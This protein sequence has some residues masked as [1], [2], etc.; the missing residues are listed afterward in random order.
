MDNSFTHDSSYFQP[1]TTLGGVDIAEA[2]AKY[3]DLFAD[4]I[5]DGTI[6][7]ER[8]AH[9]D[10]A[11]A[12]LGLESPRVKQIEEALVASHEVRH[13]ITVV[14]EAVEAEELSFPRRSSELAPIATSEEPGVRALQLRIGVLEERNDELLREQRQLREQIGSLEN[15]VSRLQGALETTMDD[16]DD[17][18]RELERERN[19]QLP[20]PPDPTESAPP[21]ARHRTMA[22]RPNLRHDPAEM[23]RLLRKSPREPELHRA[24]FRALGR[25]ADI[26][27][28]WCIVH[29]LA[30]LGAADEAELELYHEYAETQLVKP[31]RAVNDDEWRELLFHPLEDEITGEI[32]AAIAPAV[33]LGQ[34]TAVRA[35][36]APEVLDPETKVEPK[37]STLQSVR[38]VSWAAAFLGL[39]LPPVHVCPDHEGMIEVVL[40]PVPTTKLGRL[41]VSGRS[42]RELAFV[43]GQHLS[44]YR[45]EHLLGKPARSIRRL[46][47]VF[48]AALMLGN[49]GLPMTAEIRRRVEPIVKTI[50]PLLDIEAIEKLQA[51]F[52]RFVEFGGRTNLRQ[53]LG[54]AERKADCAGLLLSNDLWAAREMLM[55]TS[56]DRAAEAIDELLCFVTADRYTMLRRRIG[57]AIDVD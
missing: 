9:L 52:T 49:P 17:V 5:W 12:M 16:L 2:E 43:V 8:R 4:V 14:E 27:R 40:N 6:S 48:L 50:R 29:A 31:R 45:G 7:S 34:L 19:S 3:A 21:S 15:L 41:A 44:W 35:T 30:F 42:S 38:C 25:S 24:L 22:P 1:E 47:D 57:I 56:P 39:R 55:L 11:A 46:E 10:A 53:W 51:C 54:G 18:G 26:D 32:L 37:H 33:L 36:I 13:R 20:L 23:H 28:R